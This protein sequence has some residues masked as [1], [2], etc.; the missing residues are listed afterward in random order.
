[1]KGNSAS[2]DRFLTQFLGRITRGGEVYPGAVCQYQLARFEDSAIILT[3]RGLAFSSIENPI[4]D[5]QDSKTASTLAPVEAA[6]LIRQVL[7]WVPAERDDMRVVLQAVVGGKTTPSGLT[8]AVR[9]RFPGDWS[10][11]V[12]QTHLSG[13]IAR[14]GEI[15]LLRRSWQGRNVNYQ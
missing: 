9:Q 11:S 5:K 10:D 8:E 3:D 4:L 14:L 7:E 1:R 12:F 6:F 2:R 13:L 15:R